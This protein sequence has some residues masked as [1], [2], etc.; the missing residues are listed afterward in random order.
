MVADLLDDMPNKSFADLMVLKELEVP[1]T[2]QDSKGTC[3]YFQS[4]CKPFK[5]IVAPGVFGGHVLA[6]CAIAGA[7]TVGKKYILHNIHGYFILPG[8]QDIP[9]IYKVETIR[10]GRSYSVRQIRV[11]Q[12]DPEEVDVDDFDFSSKKMCFMGICSYKE[13]EQASLEH[14]R[15]LDEKLTL[16]SLE[17]S[18]YRLPLAPDVDIPTWETWAKDPENKY[19][20][21]IHPIEVRKMKMDDYNKD[22][23]QVSDRRQIHFLKSHDRLPNDFNMHI[24]ALLY[25]SDRNSL[26]TVVNLQH[27]NNLVINRI[28]SIDHSF[29]M[30]SLDTRVDE[31]WMTME[32][33]SD[34]STDGRG[35][36]NGRIYDSNHKL[37]CSFMQDGVIRMFK[38]E[39]ED[40]VNSKL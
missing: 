12:P 10:N 17:D 38:E 15:N 22:K 14:Q 32:T 40:K 35:L 27:P 4:T 21:E 9:F 7:K 25:A 34:R 19:V 30:H 8:Q 11:Y 37:V 20:Q 18:I 3:H 6:Q 29:V 23:K 24:A 26:F 1:K 16:Q 33:Y 5:P 28:A 39:P 31:G 13:P 36:Y 2:Q